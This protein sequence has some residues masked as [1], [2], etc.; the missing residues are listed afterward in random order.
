[1]PVYRIEVSPNNR[2]GCNDT[3]HKKEKVKIMKGEPRFGTWVEIEEH[4]SWR[5]KHWGCVSGKQLENLRDDI[6]NGDSY[7]FDMIDGYDEIGDHPELQA[8]I[9]T[10]MIEGKIADED[11]NGDP[12]YNVL[13]QSGIR[14]RATKKKA[15]PEDEN[16]EEQNGGDT[17]AKKPTKKRGRKKAG[18]DA[19]EEEE[20][21]PAEAPPTKKAR[22]GK[23][24][25][26]ADDDEDAPPVEAP[27]GKGRGKKAK[28]EPEAHEEAVVEAEAPKKKGRAKKTKA[29]PEVDDERAVE[30]PKKRGRAKKAK[31][32]P[33]ADKE[34]SEDP[35]PEPEPELEPVAKKGGRKKK[36]AANGDDHQTEAPK[37]APAKRGRPKKR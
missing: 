24:K 18:E 27:K 3:L 6:R 2:A 36:A 8:K 7:D 1:M 5:W 31:V 9:R 26:Q 32:E 34:A 10:A 21:E 29:E 17:P 33:E 25:K 30:Q 22:K 15:D 35:E 23:A 14:G 20:Q 28:P 11:F 12:E 16:A 19:E 4:G 13:G 37:V